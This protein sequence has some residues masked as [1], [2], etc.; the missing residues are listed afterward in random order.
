MPTITEA[1]EVRAPV[2]VAYDQWTQFEQFPRFMEG[3]KEVRQIDDTR[4]HW[5]AEIAGRELEWDATITEQ[6]P[7]R[8]IAWRSTGGV[9]NDGTVS[10]T[11]LADDATRVEVAIDHDPSGL[12]ERAADATGVVERRV[13]GDLERFRELVESGEAPTGAW[14]GEVH[15]GEVTGGDAAGIGPEGYPERTRLPSLGRLR[16]MEV[17]DESGEKVGKVADVFLDARAEHVRYITVSTG[18]LSRG[19]HIVPVDD[20]TYVDE[21]DGDAYVTVPY[22]REQL[23]GAPTF[24]DDEEMTP[25]R[26]REIYGYYDRVGYWEEAREAVRARQTTPAPTPEIAEAEVA[27]AMS[28]GDSP[29]SVRVKR[30]GV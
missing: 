29:S 27:D 7:D 19:S 4:L 22:S 2:R 28:R 14:R 30:W 12:G 25:E 23:K 18:W 21:E 9:R 3:V 17:R 6:E 10:F 5:V 16:G 15:G 1:V 24:D 13:R 8:R 20:V 11:P 26:E